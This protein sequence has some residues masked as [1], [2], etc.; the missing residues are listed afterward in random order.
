M[1]E[2]LPRKSMCGW[3][4]WRKEH[5][6]P[7]SMYSYPCRWGGEDPPCTGWWNG[8]LPASVPPR[9]AL[10]QRPSICAPLSPISDMLVADKKLSLWC[11]MKEPCVTPSPKSPCNV[12]GA[13]VCTW[14]RWPPS[15]DGGRKWKTLAFHLG[16]KGPK[17]LWLCLQAKN[18][19]S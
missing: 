9:V 2:M 12:L 18:G 17:Q 15:C 19:C 10:G 4:I 11:L 1:D 8:R 14:N 5:L 3:I 6:W 13:G 7:V 16:T